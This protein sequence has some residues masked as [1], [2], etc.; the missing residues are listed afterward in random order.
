MNRIFKE[1]NEDK[2]REKQPYESPKI[3]VLCVELEHSI[4]AGSAKISPHDSENN[5]IFEQWEEDVDD[6]RTVEW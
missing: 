3:E 2:A 4:A 1:I 6:V 5:K